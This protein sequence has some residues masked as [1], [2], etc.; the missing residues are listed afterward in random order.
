MR[1]ECKTTGTEINNFVL[2]RHDAGQSTKIVLRRCGHVCIGKAGSS[3]GAAAQC[4]KCKPEID[5]NWKCDIC[6]YTPPTEE[7]V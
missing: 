4:H 3:F 6:R 5:V 1:L 2:V 7:D